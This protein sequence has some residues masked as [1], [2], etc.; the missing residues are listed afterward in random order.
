MKKMIVNCATC[1]M[2]KVSEETLQS[3]EQIVVN[4]ALVLV[5]NYIMSRKIF[6]K[7]DKK[8]DKK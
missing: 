8:E 2:R 3:Y 4:S 6:K 7:T 1:D 5:I